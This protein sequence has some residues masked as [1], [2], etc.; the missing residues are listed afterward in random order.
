MLV[1]WEGLMDNQI[2]KDLNNDATV[3]NLFHDALVSPN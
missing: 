3:Y 2:Q 1:M